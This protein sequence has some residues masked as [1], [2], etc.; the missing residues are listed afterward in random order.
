MTRVLGFSETDIAEITRRRVAMTPIDAQ[1]A[2]ALDAGFGVI[3]AA[4]ASLRVSVG[5]GGRAAAVAAPAAAAPA[6]APQ[7]GSLAPGLSENQG[8]GR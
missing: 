7:V 3:D 4:S 5:V 6:A 2:A 1:L 8:G